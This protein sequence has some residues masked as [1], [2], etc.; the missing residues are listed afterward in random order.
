MKYKVSVDE[1]A[2]VIHFG[3]VEQVDMFDVKE[4]RNKF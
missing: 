4:I 2:A 3:H 1:N